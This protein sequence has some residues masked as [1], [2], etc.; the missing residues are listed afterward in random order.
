MKSHIKLITLRFPLQSTTYHHEHSSLL[1]ELQLSS[2]SSISDQLNQQAA[3][4][5][6]DKVRASCTVILV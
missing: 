5:S 2:L 3:H 4:A 1:A 6:D